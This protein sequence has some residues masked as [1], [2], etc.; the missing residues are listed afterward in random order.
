MIAVLS[1]VRRNC[2]FAAFLFKFDIVMTELVFF[3]EQNFLEIHPMG[4]L[5]NGDFQTW[6]GHLAR[7]KRALSHEMPRRITGK[8]PV[9][10]HFASP[11]HLIAD[12][13]QLAP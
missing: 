4:D 2:P 7:E 1:D 11:M 6:H 8:M 12:G 9:P 3:Q 5:R 10:R 13:R